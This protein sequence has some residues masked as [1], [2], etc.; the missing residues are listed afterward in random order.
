MTGLL[1]YLAFQGAMLA[2]DSK[3]QSGFPPR[4]LAGQDASL[5]VANGEYQSGVVNTFD[6]LEN[7]SSAPK[8]ASNH[9]ASATDIPVDVPTGWTATSAHVHLHN[10]S[11]PTEALE[12]N[13]FSTDASGWSYDEF[14]TG[15][16]T[17]YLAGQY[18]GGAEAVTLELAEKE[19]HQH[20][21][22][23]ENFTGGSVPA[24]WT[25]WEY[26]PNVEIAG[27]YANDQGDD[28]LQIGSDGIT[29]DGYANFSKTFSLDYVQVQASTL[30]FRYLVDTQ[31]PSAII[32]NVTARITKL[33]GASWTEKW[34]KTVFSGAS[35]QGWTQVHEAVTGAFDLGSGDYRIE[36]EAYFDWQVSNKFARV[37]FTDVGLWMD[38]RHTFC[39]NSHAYWNQV[40]DL[41]TY[42]QMDV[43]DA[44][45]W[46][47]YTA[48]VG[49]PSTTTAYLACWLGDERVNLASFSTLVTDNAPHLYQVPL[50]APA[51]AHWEG[52]SGNFSLGV[53]MA[54]AGLLATQDWTLLVDDVYLWVNFSSDDATA[55]TV[56][57][58]EEDVAWVEFGAD[59]HAQLEATWTKSELVLQLQ[60]TLAPLIVNLS[61]VVEVS[62][63]T[64]SGVDARYSLLAPNASFVTWNLTMATTAGL[65]G[66]KSASDAYDL[67]QYNLTLVNLPALDYE[68]VDTRDWWVRHGFSPGSADT[69]DSLV[70]SSSD[71]RY[72]NLTVPSSAVGNWDTEGRGTWWF[73]ATQANALAEVWMENTSHLRETQF[74]STN[75]TFYNATAGNTTVSGN[76]IFTLV[77]STGTPASVDWPQ[78]EQ[79]VV[80]KASGPW[81][82][83]DLA[84]GQ[85]WL[86]CEWN[87]TSAGV[88]TR[89]GVL[90]YSVAIARATHAELTQAD[91]TIYSGSLGE[92]A[93]D[94]NFTVGGSQGVSGASIT[95]IN[96]AT[97]NT[98]GM[99]FTGELQV[100]SLQYQGE[101]NYTFNINTFTVPGGNY[102]LKIQCEKPYYDAQVLFWNISLTGSIMNYSFTSGVV[103]DDGEFYLAIGNIP[104][105]NQTDF[106]VIQLTLLDFISGDPLVDA[107]ITAKVEAAIMPWVEIYKLTG[108]STDRGKYN[109][110]VDATG[111]HNTSSYNLSIVMQ[112]TNY[113]QNVTRVEFSPRAIP[114]EIVIQEVPPVLEGGT[115]QLFVNFLDVKDPADPRGLRNA[116]VTYEIFN[117]TMPWALNGTLEGTFSGVYSCMISLEEPRHLA[118]GEYT[119]RINASLVDCENASKSTPDFV[120]FPKNA[121]KVEITLPGELRVGQTREIRVRLAH[122]NDTAIG[123]E[124]IFVNLTFGSGAR[125]LFTLVT[126][127]TGEVVTPITPDETAKNI[128]VQGHFQGTTTR[129]PS[130]TS[131]FQE[132]L[133]RY[134]SN[135]TFSQVPAATRVG[136]SILVVGRLSVENGQE[137]TGLLVTYNCY[138]DA[139]PVTFQSGR[140]YADVDGAFN[141]T[142]ESI[143]SGKSSL[144]VTLMFSGTPAIASTANTTH[145]S[146]LPKYAS[147]LS[148]PGVVSETRVGEELT[149]GIQLELSV[150]MAIEGRGLVVQ[151]YYDAE[152][153][154]FF[155]S[156]EFTDSGG[157][158]NLSLPLVQD[159]HA[160]LAIQ[161]HFLETPTIA[162][163]TNTTVIHIL[164]KIQ[165]RLA[166]H[167][168]TS[169]VQ[170]GTRFQVNTSLSFTPVEPASGRYLSYSVYIPTRVTPV[171][172]GDGYTDATGSFLIDVGV[173]PETWQSFTILVQ[174]SGTIRISAGNQT[175]TWQVAP[176]T[177]TRLEI[178]D[179]PARVF[180]NLPLLITTRLTSDA[181]VP[182]GEEVVFCQVGI[183]RYTALTSANGTATFSIDVEGFRGMQNITIGYVGHDGYAETTS[184]PV[185]VE[186]SS[187]TDYQRN[188]VLFYVVLGIIGAVSAT[189]GVVLHRKFVTAPRQRRREAE[190]LTLHE[191]LYDAEII[192]SVV[193]FNHTGVDLFSR[194]YS[195]Y[196]VDPT[197]IGGFL[198]AV[199]MFGAEM[200]EQP[201]KSAKSGIKALSYKQ[202]KVHIE[203]GKFSKVAL[204][205]R[206]K[207]SP[208]L[209]KNLKHL[210]KAFETRY[211]QDLRKK[212][213]SRNLPYHEI[214]DILVKYLDIHLLE[215]STLPPS[216]TQGQTFTE[217]ERMV[218]E[219]ARGLEFLNE[220]RLVNLI[221]HM[222]SH[223]MS[224]ELEVLRAAFQMVDRGVFEPI[225]EAIFTFREKFQNFLG[226]LSNRDLAVLYEFRA[227]AAN[228]E[229][230]SEILHL[231]GSAISKSLATLVEME[232]VNQKGTKLTKLGNEIVDF[233]DNTPRGF[234]YEF[235]GPFSDF[236]CAA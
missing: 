236:S 85:Y 157:L 115:S 138:Y 55:A 135:L 48:P 25:Y 189:S 137:I 149:V 156:S 112:K 142:I 188:R 47:N 1:L 19:E 210:V 201:R 20:Y 28:A 126:N 145:I 131:V 162:P 148:F 54:Q 52:A 133:S 226:R 204:L 73:N 14:S 8:Q 146:I 191:R 232:L 233:L 107:S 99:D 95:V 158:T 134:H 3:M 111:L 110:T 213:T 80:A 121:T 70:R 197:L 67:T 235:V 118:P 109:I 36:L 200:S 229:R 170:A 202:F 147:A 230:I 79:D 228:A 97:G 211:D 72:Q 186:V 130:S 103:Q 106:T 71:P 37:Y 143:A 132:I 195:E 83:P 178:L 181:G 192:Q 24:D 41:S 74:Y 58:R 46:F 10:Y 176:K 171:L 59:N 87:D 208:K 155:A 84:P 207:P 175:G 152:T 34:E 139:S 40:V 114:T 231:P 69:N 116:E 16:D 30:S 18:D 39:E 31:T 33:E 209:A 15:N 68:G 93:V 173:I 221:K 64:A 183:R 234:M 154:P 205:L 75:D 215:W 26:D 151:C 223:Y 222:S 21:L 29:I 98:W 105:V 219:L 89:F 101:G 35:D 77:D 120:V 100:E 78:Y 102:T 180:D 166:I 66:L 190:L 23:S 86:V 169:R 182:L 4:D 81:T 2:W 193:I 141:I 163:A 184:S 60:A 7:C 161:A 159:G 187:Y 218:V 113:N 61:V 76:Y 57:V 136:E 92:F 216:K 45:L 227:C 119:L 144:S 82:V 44:T 12:N 125:Q 42:A 11:C 165:A 65:D 108:K 22:V 49:L 129:H 117:A 217:I 160:Q 185:T 122:V 153:T 220:F 50:P 5:S 96:N 104:A 196:P 9:N 56:E 174:F 53:F 128:T 91:A 225:D 194:S 150:P 94:Y 224:R 164:P 168:T 206:H 17:Q 13:A 63:L 90:N 214:R 179:M 203:E 127:E 172:T 62:D 140:L 177:P 123:G 167:N 124:E 43:T 32:I 212:Y 38:F 27:S 198:S 6:L 199:S 51:L 88:T